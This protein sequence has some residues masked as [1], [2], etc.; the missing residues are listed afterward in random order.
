MLL[1]ELWVGC[2]WCLLVFWVSYWVLCIGFCLRFV[3]V[4]VFVV[5]D[6]V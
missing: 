4:V 2:L 6:S 3:V 1:K 5:G